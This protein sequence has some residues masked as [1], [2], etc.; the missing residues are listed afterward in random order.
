MSAE[1][2]PGHPGT[3]TGTGDDEEIETEAFW[4]YEGGFVDEATG[5]AGTVESDE[6]HGEG[7][8]W[9]IDLTRTGLSDRVVYPEPVS[10]PPK[11]LGDG[12]WYT[13]SDT[14]DTVRIWALS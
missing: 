2:V 14:G 10:G 3:D 6:E 4:D 5:I 8:Q 11:A 12:T 9:L 1:A 13:V 7:R